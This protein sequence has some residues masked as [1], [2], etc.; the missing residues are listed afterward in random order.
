MGA[1][2]KTAALRLMESAVIRAGPGLLNLLA[3]GLL[4]DRLNTVSYGTYSTAFATVTTLGSILF[5]PIIYG[6]LPEYSRNAKGEEESH[7]VSLIVGVVTVIFG[8]S[9][10]IM[11]VAQGIA[12]AILATIG[13]G[14]MTALQELLRGKLRLWSYGAV[15]LSQS[16]TFVG[17]IFLLIDHD[18][19]ELA[20]WLYA[21]SCVIGMGVAFAL[22]GFPSLR[23]RGIGRLAQAVKVGGIYTASTLV[24][25]GFILGTRYL[26]LAFNAREILAIY[27]F[28]IDISQRL[29][30]VMINLATFQFVPRA[31]KQA[32]E[33]GNVAFLAILRQGAGVG[34]ITALASMLS[35]LGVRESGLLPSKILAL[36]DPPIFVLIALGLGINRLKKLL[37]DPVAIR[38]NKSQ[39]IL[40]GYLVSAPVTFA[41][42]AL[43]LRCG[44][45]YGVAVVLMCGYSLATFIA[46][47]GYRRVMGAREKLSV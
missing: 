24:E 43:V 36:L 11:F 30:G 14:A 5:G 39:F 47:M 6:V 31:Y 20:L 10:T 27:S 34:A 29:V 45:Y 42:V 33:E 16:L 26:F 15:A 13:S 44:S 1:E 17:L 12:G 28:C 46:R 21:G 22:L 19:P 8:F 23:L 32:E 4:A 2:V 41:S 40:I 18:A 38:F 7:F 35:I 9:I 3:L 25:G 37:V